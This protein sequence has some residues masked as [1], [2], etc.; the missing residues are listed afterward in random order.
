MAK[1]ITMTPNEYADKQARNLSN[2]T[3]DI[4][5]GVEAV[6]VCPSHLT[7]A[8]LMKMKNNFN[9]S[10][11]SGKTKRRM[12]SVSLDTWKKNTIEVGISRIPAGIAKARPKVVAFAEE[13]FA[14]E[15]EG[16]QKLESMPSVTFD[17]SLN[18]MTEWARHMKNFRR[19]G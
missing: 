19:K 6:T 12:H 4:R 5:R 11:D 8:Q 15:K 7:D 17:D 2:A 13:L 18:R 10:M 1:S 3:A 9:E 16:L 14:H